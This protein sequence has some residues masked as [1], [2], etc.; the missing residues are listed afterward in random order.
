MLME[1]MPVLTCT[2]SMAHRD[3]SDDDGLYCTPIQATEDFGLQHSL[4]ALI[5]PFPALISGF[6]DSG[7]C[8]P[9]CLVL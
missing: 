3:A 1:S 5:S 2:A 4:T 6:C 9:S 7:S 8:V